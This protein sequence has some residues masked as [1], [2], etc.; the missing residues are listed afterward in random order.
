METRTHIPK[1]KIIAL[2]VADGR[3]RLIWRAAVYFAIGHWAL[4][5]LSDRL[6]PILQHAI[7]LAPGFTAANLAIDEILLFVIALVWT[8]ILS[9][10]ERRRVDSYGLPVTRA[11]GANTWE[12]AACGVVAAGGVAMGML[13]LGGMKIEGGAASSARPI[14]Y[15]SSCGV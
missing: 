8:G 5:P 12:G 10:Y 7:G 15:A 13:V 11:L 6:S 4:N 1:E 9:A 14:P 2:F 3:V